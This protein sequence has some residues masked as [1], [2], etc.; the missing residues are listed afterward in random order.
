[1]RRQQIAKPS[2]NGVPP[3]RFPL[4]LRIIAS[5]ATQPPS[6]PA[7]PNFPVCNSINRVP[8]CVSTVTSVQYGHR[9]LHVARWPPMA[10]KSNI[11][12]AAR[13]I[14]IRSALKLA[15]VVV[16]LLFFHVYLYLLPPF[17]C[18]VIV[19]HSYLPST[20]LQSESF[21]SLLCS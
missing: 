11:C 8:S 19:D 9:F 6:R 3:G 16:L 2:K 5:I 10:P 12:V 14:C 7:W 4:T 13:E 18:R 20:R 15:C 21:A 1:M 17:H